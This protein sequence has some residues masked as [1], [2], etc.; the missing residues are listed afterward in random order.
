MPVKPMPANRDDLISAL[1]REWTRLGAELV[2]LSQG[3]AE[4]LKINTTDLQCL[5]VIAG[6]GP[7]TAGQVAE[8]TGLT[9][10]AITGVVDRL[11]HAGLV[12]RESDPTDRRRVVVRAVPAEEGAGEDAVS[13]TLAGLGGAVA[14]Q[15]EDY[16]DRELQLL[17]D[18]LG[19]A[20]PVLLDHVARV[21]GQSPAQH[22]LA[23]P[24]PG[25][26]AAR[27]VLGPGMGSVTIDSGGGMA[28]L[29]RA[30]VAGTPPEITVDGGTVT[31]RPRRFAMFGWGHREFR[32]TLSDAVAWDVEVAQGAWRLSAE[33][34]RVRLRSFA[35]RGGA[36]NVSLR[37][38][39]PSGAVPVS[40]EGGA[41][42]VTVRRPRGVPVEMHV[43]GGASR[44]SV[45]GRDLG[46]SAR[47]LAWP[48]PGVVA[49][50]DRYVVTVQ[51]GA[52]RLSVEPD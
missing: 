7:M 21:R 29:Y 6:Q 12:R 38:G 24:P 34:S 45:D 22:Q 9:T 32:L 49:D 13:G 17:V 18:A 25:T 14:E 10:G 36:S 52:S 31:V 11:E 50:P 33:L 47:N 4:R 2:L 16:S 42:R 41:S 5:A 39:P 8:A 37:L 23:G 3:V 28:E 30:D 48:E 35:V 44:V 46:P 26:E 20:H 43:R 27:L 51:G 40:I 19:R 1:T 15:Y